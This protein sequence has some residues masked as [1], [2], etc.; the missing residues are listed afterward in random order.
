MEWEI[1][2]YKNENG[3]ITVED[4]YHFPWENKDWDGGGVNNRNGPLSFLN[5]FGNAYPVRDEWVKKKWVKDK[6]T[7]GANCAKK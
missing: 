1:F 5:R 2:R 6:N 3:K 4:D 7:E